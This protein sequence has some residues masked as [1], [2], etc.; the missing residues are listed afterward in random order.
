[1]ALIGERPSRIRAPPFRSWRPSSSGA[2][3]A[4]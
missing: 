2:P 1:M 3:S 4:L